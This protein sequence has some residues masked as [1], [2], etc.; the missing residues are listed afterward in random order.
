MKTP[1][2][3]FIFLLVALLFPVQAQ[4]QTEA[5]ATTYN[6]LINIKQNKAEVEGNLLNWI[7]IF[8]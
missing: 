1:V 6:G 5:S 8:C 4:S 7:W 2:Y 3:I